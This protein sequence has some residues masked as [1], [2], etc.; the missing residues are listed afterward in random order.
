[1][2]PRAPGVPQALTNMAW[3][4][5]GLGE[6]TRGRIYGSI[7]RREDSTAS[8]E[9]RSL[10]VTRRRRIGPGIPR[11]N[12]PPFQ[13]PDE[14]D[15]SEVDQQASGATTYFAQRCPRPPAPL[16]HPRSSTSSSSTGGG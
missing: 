8:S 11:S 4:D 10:A 16:L 5:A 3:Y 15:L 6:A 9:A 7:R 14:Q 1:M 13:H 12:Q 2:V